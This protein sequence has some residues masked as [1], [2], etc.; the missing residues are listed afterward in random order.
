[1]PSFK[2][3]AIGKNGEKIEN[4]YTAN[5]KEDVVAMMRGNNY[6]PLKIEE[7]VEGTNIDSKLFVRVKTKDI[8]IF[9][10]QFYTM[11]NAGATISMCLNILGQQ[12]TNKKLKDSIVSVDEQV[13]KGL[14]FS[15]A[16]K[17]QGTIFPDL[18]IN[19]VN[20][21]EV[22]GTLDTVMR[23]MAE[24]YEK[25]SK[26]NNK[27]KAAMVYPTVLGIISVGVV[28][29]MLTFVMPIFVGM[30]KDNGVILPAPTKMLLAT[31]S[32]LK[33]FWYLFIVI[34]LGIG[35]VLKYYFKTENGQIFSSKM[36]L[37]LPIF[38]NI[39]EK[40]IISRF[41]RTLS[42]VLTSG[43]NLIQALQ[44]VSK[45]LGN[46]IIENKVMEVREQMM[47][48]GVLSEPLAKAGFFPPMLCSM[49]KIGEESG[50]LDE[51]LDKTADFYDDELDT[52][53]QQ[54]TSILEPLMIL[55]M[56]VVIGFMVV[57]ML[58]PMFDM[59]NNIQ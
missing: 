4:V 1:M 48:G 6:Y 2:Y 27:V 47:K 19:M 41:T 23:R 40:I 58:L 11:L 53:I 28:I 34:I 26:I 31:S 18:F 7:I 30:F 10:R 12:I 22:S 24:H 44:V 56:G 38:K 37:T 8:A 5:T 16:L 14:T 35:F 45:V 9:C 43:V 15:E 36:K 59:Y 39:N 33:S 17:K 20:S 21:G 46:K 42:T 54:F 13:R 51:I 29:A 32:F 25:E 52:A 49:I 50:S 55:I 3:K 57:A